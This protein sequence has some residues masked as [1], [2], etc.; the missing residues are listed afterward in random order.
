MGRL[1]LVLLLLSSQRSNV[2]TVSASAHLVFEDF[3]NGPNPLDKWDT[4]YSAGTSGRI[5]VLRDQAGAFEAISTNVTYC[6]SSPCYRAELKTPDATRQAIFSSNS[7]EYWIGLSTRIPSTWQWVPGTGQAITCDIF[8]IHGG[9][10]MGQSPIVGIR[11]EGN[12][13]RI[14]ICGNTALSSADSS[15]RYFSLGNVISGQWEHWVIYDKLSYDDTSALT[16]GV[17]RVWRNGVLVV[18]TSNL[19]TSYNDVKPHYLKFGTY[20]IQW[21][22]PPVA[23]T[24]VTWVGSEYRGLRVGNS[25]SSYAEVYTGSTGSSAPSD[26]PTS[27]PTRIPTLKPTLAPSR[28]PSSS[29]TRR[30]SI[31]S[32]SSSVQPTLAPSRGPSAAFT[33]R[34][35]VASPSSSVLTPQPSMAPLTLKPSAVSSTALSLSPTLAPSQ[36]PSPSSLLTRKPS[37]ALGPSMTQRPSLAPSLSALTRRPSAASSSTLTA[38]PSFLLTRRPSAAFSSALTPRPSLALSRHPSFALT[39]RPSAA[40]PLP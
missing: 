26:A 8:Q 9:D 36:G 30:P 25:S 40:F 22:A 28:A 20:I 13:Y 19:L 4:D 1:L 10:N 34:P 17:V 33:H 5:G 39:R 31:A 7:G 32:P 38:R 3:F 23:N 11:N 21:R 6:P 12:R 18:E 27:A 37:V 2:P 14:N 29:L 15:C 35:S 24:T 16:R